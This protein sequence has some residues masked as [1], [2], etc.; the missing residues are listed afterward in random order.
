MTS[1]FQREPDGQTFDLLSRR[2]WWVVELPLVFFWAR[3][4]S[5]A[6]LLNRCVRSLTLILT[7]SLFGPTTPSID[8][9]EEPIL[10]YPPQKIPFNLQ[11]SLT[12]S[13]LFCTKK[14]KTD[15]N[16][17]KIPFGRNRSIL[18]RRSHARTPP[19]R[20]N[21]SFVLF[22]FLLLRLSF[23][24]FLPNFS[25]VKNKNGRMPTSC[26]FYSLTSSITIWISGFFGALTY[27][28]PI[29]SWY[30]YFTFPK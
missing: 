28:Q 12:I 14:N 5:E 15:R 30:F 13:L 29:P 2:S 3:S 7:S 17:I 24:L 18:Q 4:T 19:L 6:I 21:I 22:F 26:A 8:E 25:T 9:H 20:T 10:A 23:F 27:R 1:S 16:W 11:F